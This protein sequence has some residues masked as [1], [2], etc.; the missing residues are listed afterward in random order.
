[1]TNQSNHLT[2]VDYTELAE[3]IRRWG[4]ELHLSI[5]FTRPVIPQPHQKALNDWLAQGYHGDMHFMTQ[6]QH[7]RLNPTLLHEDCISIISARLAYWTE[8]KQTSLTVLQTPK[9][10]YISRYALGRD[11]HKIL[12]SQLKALA[13][14]IEQE[15]GS[16]QWR[17]FAD[18][19]P[20]MEH[21][22]AQQAGLGFIGKHT[23]L[24]HPKAGSTFFLGELFC[25]LPLPA[26]EPT[27]RCGCGPCT[28]CID[29]C[30]TQAIVAP[31]TVDARRCISYLTIEYDGVID[32][33]L[34]PLMGN[35]IYGCD[36]CQ[37]TC[38]WNKFAQVSAVADF[39]TRYQLNQIGLLELWQWSETDFLRRFEG[40]PIRRIGYQQWRRNLAIA[41]GNSPQSGETQLA[42]Q[43]ALP[44]ATPLVAEHLHWALQRQTQLATTQSL[45]QI[46]VLVTKSFL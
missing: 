30:P 4:E 23:L 16:F 29:I 2:D 11:Y 31:F 28:N 40:S 3:K 27:E 18:S 9:Q 8:A 15:I 12:R 38:P 34:R 1:M 33:S 32:K 13:L 5:G 44:L 26:D 25:N 6:H 22:L 37:L 14:R 39:A 7:L 42:L 21:V 45:S 24:I 19:A 41:L 46:P 36:D 10:A 35:R 20:I 17:P 43:Q